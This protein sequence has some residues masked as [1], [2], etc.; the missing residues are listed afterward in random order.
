MIYCLTGTLLEKTLDNVVID[1]QGVGF[2]L[3]VPSTVQGVLPAPGEKC[4][5]YTYL[6]VK[7]DALDLYGFAD[8]AEQKAFKTLISVSGVGPKAGLSILSVLSPQKIALAVT[9]GDYKAFTA[10]NGVGPK[11]A[12]RIVLELKGKFSNDDVAGVTMAD[13]QRT[14]VSTG[15][16]SQAISALIAL[17]YNQSQAAL[18]VSK[19]DADGDVQTLI[20]QALK[21]LA[22]GKI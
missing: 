8:K 2:S 11:V 17:G 12:Q 4:T 9:T 20:K 16:V 22:G 13:V 15:S 19:L 3:A 18:A 6:S 21:L 1:V 7:E 14:A 10:A 5:L